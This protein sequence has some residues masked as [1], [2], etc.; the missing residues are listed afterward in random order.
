MALPY[1]NAAFDVAVETAVLHHVAEPDRVIAEMLRVSRQAIFIS[2]SNCYALGGLGARLAKLGLARAGA[3][4]RVNRLRRGGHDWYYTAG[5][6]VGWSYS[7]YDSLPLIRS[8][9]ADAHR[10]V[11]LPTYRV[12]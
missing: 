10:G 2:D 6:G 1:E 11:W 5:D 7:V 3:L 9:S 4:E 12:G 8:A